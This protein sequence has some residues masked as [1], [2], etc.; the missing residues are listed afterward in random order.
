MREIFQD[1]QIDLALLQISE[2]E[3][4]KWVNTADSPRKIGNFC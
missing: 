1:V 4:E 3:L 2:N